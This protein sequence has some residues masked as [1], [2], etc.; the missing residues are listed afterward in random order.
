[1]AK[2]LITRKIPE[3]TDAD[4]RRW[5][6]KV[7][8]GAPTDCWIWTGARNVTGYGRFKLAG[9]SSAFLAHRVGYRL[10][11]GPLRSG[12]PL[13]HLCDNRCCVNP[14][15]LKVGSCR[16]NTWDMISKGRHRGAVEVV[17]PCP[18]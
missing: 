4:R 3:L 16:R 5:L 11:K 14:E 2:D 10:F 6:R 15:H 18:Y 1:M 9:F 12:F 13:M 17:G 7:W 8:R